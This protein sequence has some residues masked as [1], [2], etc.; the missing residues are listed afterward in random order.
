VVVGTS[1]GSAHTSV[2]DAT[3]ADVSLVVINGIPRAGTPELMAAAGAPKTGET[4]SVAGHPR[5]LN[6]AQESAD[7]AVAAV[8]AADA[9]RLLTAALAALPDR[10]HGRRAAVPEGEVRLAVEGLV[11]DAMTS[12][13]HLPF[14]GVQT[15]PNRRT[16]SAA[17]G[18]GPALP[19]LKL[20]PLTAADN[21]AFYATVAAEMN[22]PPDVR[23]G[24]MTYAA[25]RR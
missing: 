17:D 8:S 5:L 18:P 9:E 6:L 22:L 7:S 21:P 4:I 1:A 10:A 20:D 11:D 13:H 25:A 2:I 16:T 23:D 19:S 14:H 3:E 12:R 24:L 15:G